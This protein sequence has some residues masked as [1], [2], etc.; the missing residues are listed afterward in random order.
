MSDVRALIPFVAVASLRELSG[1]QWPMVV[2]T[3]QAI[4]SLI[5]KHHHSKPVAE[6]QHNHQLARSGTAQRFSLQSIGQAVATLLSTRPQH[7]T[8]LRLASS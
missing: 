6:S 1:R 8:I 7:A 3:D 2:F 4:E 5:S